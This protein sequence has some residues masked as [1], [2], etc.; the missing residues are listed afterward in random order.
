V[1]Y[2]EKLDMVPIDEGKLDEYKDRLIWWLQH[3]EEQ[4]KQRKAMKE[5]ARTLT[6]RSTAEGWA[7]DFEL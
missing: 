7:R 1:Q 2:G 5:W 4:E 3:P 6:W